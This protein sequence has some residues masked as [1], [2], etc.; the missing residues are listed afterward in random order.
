MK[1]LAL[2]SCGRS[3]SDLF[4]SLLDSHLQILQFPG[5]IWFNKDFENIF[6][7]KK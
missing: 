7:E 3:G 6:N 4:Q 1:I 2:V 5:P